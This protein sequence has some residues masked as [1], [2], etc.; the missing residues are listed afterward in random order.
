MTILKTDVQ[1]LT[2][3]PSLGLQ[4][5]EYEMGSDAKLT[6]KENVMAPKIQLGEDIETY[7][8]TVV[9]SDRYEPTYH[10]ET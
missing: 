9:G 6:V 4:S 2:G 1:F 5:V 7:I 10:K 8:I 3:S